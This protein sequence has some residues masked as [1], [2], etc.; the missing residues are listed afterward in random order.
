MCLAGLITGMRLEQIT[1]QE[2][3]TPGSF[4]NPRSGGTE[5]QRFRYIAFPGTRMRWP[6]T[7]AEIE[8]GVDAALA[9]LTVEQRRVIMA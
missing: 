1:A 5:E 7:R 6:Q 9:S 3:R 8:A 2:A 4:L